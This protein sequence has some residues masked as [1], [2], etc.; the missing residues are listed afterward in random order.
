MNIL[1]NAGN[2]IM[3]FDKYLTVITQIYGVWTYLLLFLIIFCETGLV[4]I[5]FLPGDSI[6]FATGALAAIGSL[7]IVMLFVIFYFAAVIGDTVNYHIGQKIDMRIIEREDFKFIKKDN[8]RKA[9][10]FY[11]KYGPI[12]IVLARF[13]PI[14]RTFAPFVA[15]IGE[16]KYAKFISYNMIGGGLWVTLGLALGYF[17]GNIPFIKQHFSTVLI[18]IVIISIIPAV[19]SFIREKKNENNNDADVI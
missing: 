4:V 12:T 5:P 2:I 11:E 17:F 10:K 7:N 14:I 18:A 15:G 3:H 13:I 6:L 8:I 9:N 1:L 16:M 19:F